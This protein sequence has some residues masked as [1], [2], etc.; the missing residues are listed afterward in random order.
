MS[1]GMRRPPALVA[2][3]VL[4]SIL[5]PAIARA[6]GVTGLRSDKVF[7]RHRRAEIT[8]DR[9]HATVVVRRTVENLGPRHDQVTFDIDVPESAVAVSLRTLGISD[10]P[11]IWFRGD[12]LEA[13]EAA[14]RYKELTS[15][16]GASGRRRETGSRP[17][18]HR[19]L[20]LRPR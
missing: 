4:T 16:G 20:E 2:L 9:G 14:R 1:Q 12:L 17:G 7:E 18:R 11:P 19:C 3:V 8:M 6:D 5:P 15:I 13:E 10:G